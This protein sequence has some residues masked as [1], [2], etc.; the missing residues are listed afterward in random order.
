MFTSCKWHCISQLSNQI[1][2]SIFLLP[3]CAYHCTTKLPAAAAAAAASIGWTGTRLATKPMHLVIPQH[4]RI[5]HRSH[6]S[7][8]WQCVLCSTANTSW[9]CRWWGLSRCVAMALWRDWSSVM[10]G[11]LWVE[12]AALPPARSVTPHNSQG[13][14]RLPSAK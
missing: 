2:L 3:H 5:Q 6:S 9:V 14:W 13:I 1:L 4:R 11:T 10:M 12:M 7:L 8:I